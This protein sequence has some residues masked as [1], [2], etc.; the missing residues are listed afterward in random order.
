[1]NSDQLTTIH[2]RAQSRPIT[3]SVPIPEPSDR[4]SILDRASL[5][6]GLRLLLHAARHS[7]A[8]TP[9]QSD[10]LRRIRQND[11]ARTQRERRAERDALLRGTGY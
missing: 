9:T 8:L 3:V 2:P 11:L 5:R 7:A 6:I 10:D 4:L 1:M